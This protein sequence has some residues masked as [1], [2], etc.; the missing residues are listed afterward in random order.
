MASEEQTAAP[1][2]EGTSNANM[3]LSDGLIATSATEEQFNIVEETRPASEQSIQPKAKDPPPNPRLQALQQKK[4]NLESTLSTLQAQKAALV[5][6]TTLPSGL[7]MPESWT[8]EE[9]TKSALATANATIKEHIS[10]LHKYNEIKDIAQGLMGL[11]AET[12]GVRVKVVMEEFEMGE[13]D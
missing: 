6:S 10:L 1:Q 9:K 5:A 2:D 3:S 12:R 11:I 8:E 4:S 7:A 13:E